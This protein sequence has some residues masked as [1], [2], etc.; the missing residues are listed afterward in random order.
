MSQIKL[1]LDVV[2]DMR[3]LADSL[4]EYANAVTGNEHLICEKPAG[5]INPADFEPIYDPTMDQQMQEEIDDKESQIPLREQVM[6]K[7]TRLTRSN[8]KTEARELIRKYGGQKFTELP[9][10]VYPDMLKELEAML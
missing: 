7:L 8:R 10:S 6:E 9:E 2:A 1:L 3:H 4:A 5:Q